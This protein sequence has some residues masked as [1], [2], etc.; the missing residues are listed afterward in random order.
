MDE[1]LA[2]GYTSDD[3]HDVVLHGLIANIKYDLDAGG[4]GAFTAYVSGAGRL[5]KSIA[6]GNKEI[7]PRVR[8]V[9][10]TIMKQV[11]LAE[12]KAKLSELVDEVRRERNPIVIQKRDTPAA[13]L[14]ELEAFRRLQENEDQLLAL[15]LREALKGKKYPLR[16]VLAELEK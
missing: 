8:K 5:R 1:T 15:K 3:D 13:V 7:N 9:R 12:A 2:C 14:V 4:S 10:S 11:K 6:T 16:K